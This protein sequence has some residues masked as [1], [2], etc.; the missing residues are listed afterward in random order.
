MMKSTPNIGM[1]RTRPDTRTRIE[2]RCGEPLADVAGQLV[3][4]R[5]EATESKKH[6]CASCGRTTT[7]HVALESR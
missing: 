5:R 2:C 6:L 1:L 7:V 4:T 3:R